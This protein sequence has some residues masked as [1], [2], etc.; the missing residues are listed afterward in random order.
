MF[1]HAI[2]LI[3]ADLQAERG[4]LSISRIKSTTAE[5]GWQTRVYKLLNRAWSNE[6]LQ[7]HIKSLETMD[8][9]P[10][11]CGQ[12]V[13]SCAGNIYFP[14]CAAIDI[15]SGLGL[16]LLLPE[17][18][19][20]ASRRQFFNNLG[21]NAAKVADIRQS[22]LQNCARPTVELEISV[23]WLK[24]LFLT[25]H[26]THGDASLAAK[27]HVFTE[28]GRHRCPSTTDIYIPND[29]PYG[30]EMFLRKKDRT[31]V[32]FIHPRYLAEIPPKAPGSDTTL[33]Q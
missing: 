7:W 30:A 22:I 12:W 24:F 16:M 19:E 11:S 1:G 33:Y 20:N 14:Q 2:A 28:G 21:V 10:L 3:R 26:L 23:Q 18:L 25:H 29:D 4:S 27:F 32:K 8:I 5:D 31:V 13:S 9:I 15:P 6:S 17:A